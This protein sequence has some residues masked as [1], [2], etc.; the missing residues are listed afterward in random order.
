MNDELVRE[1]AK[2]R[3]AVRDDTT[4]I[5]P[6]RDSAI[7]DR[8]ITALQAQENVRDAVLEEAAQYLEDMVGAEA[9]MTEHNKALLCA[10][11]WIRCALKS[12]PAAHDQSWG[13]YEQGATSG[14]GY[15]AQAPFTRSDGTTSPLR[16]GTEDRRKSAYGD[17][18]Q[19]TGWQGRRSNG[20]DGNN[21]TGRR[22][23]DRARWT[24]E[25]VEAPQPELVPGIHKAIQWFE[26]N[27]TPQPEKPSLVDWDIADEFLATIKDGEEAD[28]P[29]GLIMALRV[30]QR[31]IDARGRK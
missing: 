16:T 25:K 9:P 14:A 23:G 6:R 26:G 8:A 12:T 28:V 10:A 15:P 24:G 18:L 21:S 22:A 11:S 13:S 4:P 31:Y 2:V 1:L 17:V 7:L 20:D 3:D 27:P 5:M 19:C 29:P 30:V